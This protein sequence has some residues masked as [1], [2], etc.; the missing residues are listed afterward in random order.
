MPTQK[1]AKSAGVSLLAGVLVICIG[2]PVAAEVYTLV[3]GGAGASAAVAE[4]LQAK[5]VLSEPVLINGSKGTLT[6]AACKLSPE[7][8]AQFLKQKAGLT[9]L[10]SGAGSLVVDEKA[11][12]TE[13]RRH[14]IIRAAPNRETVVFSLRLPADAAK[15]TAAVAAW[16]TEL[17]AAPGTPE[18]AMRL[19]RTATSLS[20]YYS[21]RQP[22]A[23]A[24]EY[25]EQL[26]QAGWQVLSTDLAAGNAEYLNPKTARLVLVRTAPAPNGSLISIFCSRTVKDGGT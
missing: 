7:D 25:G 4:I 15:S 12:G 8:A 18:L 24:A 5:P 6:V 21:P 14:F 10:S 11:P 17:P 23:A 13:L 16:P 22:A 2:H 1:Q 3:P 20:T 19:D 9:I 26:R